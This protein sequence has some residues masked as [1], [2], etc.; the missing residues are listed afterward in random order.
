MVVCGFIVVFWCGLS[1]L[2]TFGFCWCLNCWMVSLGGMLVWI[3]IVCFSYCA[4]LCSWIC[5]CFVFGLCCLISLIVLFEF[6]LILR[7]VFVCLDC[8]S[9]CL[10]Y[11]FTLWLDCFVVWMLIVV[12]FVV[13]CCCF[14]LFSVLYRFCWRF[15]WLWLT[16]CFSCWVCDFVLLVC[17]CFVLI[18]LCSCRVLSVGW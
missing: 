16:C 17:V 2:Y 11:L 13:Y 9:V 1:Y 14:G 6:I 12:W 15:T 7:F 4:F 8:F 10:L 5:D 18:D 3:L